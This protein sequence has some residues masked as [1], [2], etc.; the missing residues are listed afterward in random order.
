MRRNC[1]R[2]FR[3]SARARPISFSGCKI[4]LRE[5]SLEAAITKLDKYHLLILDDLAYVAK[6]QAETS[7]L[8][9]S[10]DRSPVRPT[11]IAN[12]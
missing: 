8:F 10:P 7:A 9:E 1:S 12:A 4:A 5:L 2:A 6:D 3:A 11:I